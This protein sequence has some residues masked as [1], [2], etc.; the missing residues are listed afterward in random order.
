MQW[1]MVGI[2]IEEKDEGT[3]MHMIINEW[4]NIYCG[5]SFAGAY[6]EI[7]KQATKKSLQ[8]SKEDFTCTS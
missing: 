6:V 7:Y 1:S 5:F 3:L 4:V 2:E 8:K